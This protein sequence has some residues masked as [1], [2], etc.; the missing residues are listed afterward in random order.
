MRNSF[1]ISTDENASEM[2]FTDGK[3]RCKS[4][5]GL[6]SRHLPSA[7]K[8]LKRGPDIYKILAIK[9]KSILIRSSAKN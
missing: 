4:V 8:I 5:H 7:P 3:E 1:R 6:Q 9:I 2:M